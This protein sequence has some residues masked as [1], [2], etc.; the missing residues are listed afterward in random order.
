MG[1]LDPHGRRTDHG[2]GDDNGLRVPPRAGADPGRRCW[3]CATSDGVGD[4]ARRLADELDR[5]RA[6][7]SDVDDRVDTS[8]GRRATDWELKGVPVRIELGPRDLAEGKVVAARR[9]TGDKQELPIGSVGEQVPDL[10]TEIQDGLL[11]DAT[12]RRDA[13][14][15]EVS[16]LSDAV[17]AAQNGFAVLPWRDVGVE[18]EEI[19]GRDAV[20][21][22]C[23]RRP[24][25][26][27]PVGEDDPDALAFVARS[28]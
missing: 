3:S 6:S 11:A 25:G 21:V 1:R 28:Y 17:E 13:A 4:A 26:S 20:T 8:F 2:H 18:G 10:L 12:E 16:S 5:R 14:T 24:D 23:L 15:F 9:D 19:L 7:A 27:L 22:R